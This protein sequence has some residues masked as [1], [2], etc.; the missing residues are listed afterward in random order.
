[1]TPR[2]RRRVLDVLLLATLTVT[3][4][5]KIHWSFAGQVALEDILALLFLLVFA[6]DR[7]VRRDWTLPRGAAALFVVLLALE[8]VFLLGFFDLGTRDALDQYAKGMTKYFVHFV[9]LIAGVAHI[10]RRGKRF[11]LIAVGALCGGI[12]LNAVYGVLQLLAKVGLGVNLDKTVIGPLTQGQGGVGGINVFGQAT[13]VK[14]GSFVSLGVFRVNALVLDPNHLGIMLCVPILIL[15]PFA[16]RLGIRDRRGLA[17]AAVIAFCIGVE[18]LTLSRSGILGVAVGLLVLA[19]PLR[20]Q[21]FSLKLL[22]P[23]LIAVALIAGAASQSHYL[24]TII[25]TRVTVSDRSAQAHYQIFALVP[26]VLDEHPLLGLGLNTFSVYYE[27]QT[28]R[29]D[30]GPHSFYV[31]LIAETGLIGTTAFGLFLIW[32]LVRLA[33][34]KRAARALA[35]AGDA[36]AE[37]AGPLADG[38]LAAL[39]GTMAANIF[40]LTMQFYYFYAL[41]LVIVT[42]AELY[43]P[44]TARKPA[45]V[46]VP[47]LPRGTAPA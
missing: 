6:F 38:L 31:A 23:V 16:F 37:R 10:V 4:W 19:V 9:F 29:T 40:Y 3:T 7:L 34:L 42:A 25:K 44:A 30:W 20:R 11:H 33:V 46:A 26:P 45:P 14:G 39:V 8:V 27:F 18:I 28:G 22:V 41:V 12:T 13:G 32:L 35:R 36:D 15:L 5:A 43:A 17:L 1:V 47:S 24:R 2:A 21:I